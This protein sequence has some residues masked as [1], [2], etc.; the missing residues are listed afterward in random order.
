MAKPGREDESDSEEPVP[1]PLSESETPESSRRLPLIAGAVVVLAVVSYFIFS[2]GSGDPPSTSESPVATQALG[3]HEGFVDPA[4]CAG[5][6]AEIAASFAETGM[7]RAFYSATPEAMAHLGSDTTFNHDKSGRS[8]EILERDGAFYMQRHET[9]SDGSPINV[10]EKRIDYIM[11]SGNH[12]RT[13]I[14]QYPNGRLMEM[15]VGWYAEKGG[16]LAMSPGFDSELHGGFRREISFDCIG[17]HNGFSPM[18]LGA[19]ARSGDPLLPGK[20]AEGIGCQ[21]CHGPGREHL[22]AVSSGGNIDDIRAAI[23]NPAHADRDTQM[24]VC[25]Q[26]HLETTS[27]RLPYTVARFDRGAFSYRPG[28]PLSDFVLHFDYP[29]GV[30]EDRFE[31]AHAAYRLRKSVCFLKSEMTCTTCHDPHQAL[32]GEAAQAHFTD[33]CKTCHSDGDLAQIPDHSGAADCQTCHMP[34]RRADDVV[35]TVMTDHFIQR[36]P[37]SGDLLAALEEVSDG[38]GDAYEGPVEPYHPA[39][40]GDDPTSQLYLAVAQV[41]QQSNLD[42]GTA[43]LRELIEEHQ[44]A[45]AEFYFELAE[46]YWHQGQIEESLPW[47]EQAVTRDPEHLIALRNYSTVLGQA[48]NYPKAEDI[49]RQAL[50]VAPNDPKGLNNLADILVTLG[51]ANPAITALN[52]SLESDPD[53]PEALY[54]LARAY[55]VNGERAQGIDAA[56]RAIRVQP[57]FAAAHNT[58][59]NLLTEQGDTDEAEI[60]FRKALDLRPNYA[61]AHYNYATLLVK[62]ERFAEAE[63]HLQTAVR[64]EPTMAVA[65]GNLGNLLGMRGDASGAER[66]FRRAL[67]L[68][69]SQPQTHFNLGNALASQARLEEAVESYRRAIQIAPGYSDARLNLALTLFSMG[70]RDAALQETANITDQVLRDRA[71]MIIN[72]TL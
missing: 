21:R 28:E 51:R 49:A 26:C 59:G 63:R 39:Q 3:G 43:R 4:T 29:E 50:A 36:R 23:F 27:R 40:L 13:Y 35:H 69:S 61:S 5:C 62:R 54:N 18:E 55:G 31:I 57:E 65:H 19:D 70:D 8:Y 66:S 42:A 52:K 56:R 46:A 9:A 72:G 67:E 24:D 38:P 32:R 2:G 48:G 20:L 15:P 6:H 11:G 7:G 64:L 25:M 58:L 60:E 1:T 10:F 33:A 30:R 34:K 12:A 47:Y 14:H 68:D 16:F 41:T 53:S 37:P 45:E 22:D 71:T 44:P 17:C